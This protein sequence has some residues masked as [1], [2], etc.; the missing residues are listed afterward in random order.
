MKK[1]IAPFLILLAGCCWGCM[2]L[3]VRYFDS[4]GLDPLDIVLIRSVVT[5]ILLTG[6][7]A[8]YDRRLLKIRG[9]DLWC[10]IG[11]GIFSLVFFSICY[12]T[13]ITL[14]SLSVAAV[15]LYTA[16]AFVMLLSRF[17]F[18][19]KLTGKKLAALAMTFAGLVLVTGLAGGAQ[20]L[21]PGKILIGLGS[22][23]GYALY[24]I[25]SRYAL[26]RGYHSLTITLYT[27]I[28][29]VIGIL[30]FA[31]MRACYAAVT[32]SAGMA[33]FIL[34]YGIV[35]TAAPYILYTTGLKEVENGKASI[36]AS[37]EPVVAALLGLFV[38]GEILTGTQFFGVLLVLGGIILCNLD[39]KQNRDRNLFATEER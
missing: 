16:P 35:T 8:V 3:F 11:T 12:F 4:T 21:S 17:L 15:L 27:F 10:F 38:F 9:K 6:I 24:S 39:K 23:L 25:F 7:L 22:G 33:G 30:P 34:L 2:G 1:R 37:V 32:S 26:E 13:E 31:D 19:E 18:G 36:I 28:Y 5:V 29:S 20:R 14:T